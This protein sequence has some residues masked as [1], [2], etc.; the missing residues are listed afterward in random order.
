MGGSH[1]E[2]KRG[3][4]W[5]EGNALCLDQEAGRMGVH[6]VEFTKL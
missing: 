3:T 2:G 1:L 4:F 5:V 6:L